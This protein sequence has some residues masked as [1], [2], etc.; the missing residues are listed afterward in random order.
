M[1]NADA[2]E[3]AEYETNVKPFLT[4]IDA[5]IGSSAISGDLSRSTL[6]VTVK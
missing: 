5:L 1:A 3:R 2:A 6:I 4:P